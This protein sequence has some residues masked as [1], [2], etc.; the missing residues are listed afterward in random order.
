MN[1]LAQDMLARELRVAVLAVEGDLS[2]TLRAVRAYRGEGLE[3]DLEAFAHAEVGEHDP[4]QTRLETVMTA[5]P[6][7]VSRIF[8]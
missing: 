8:A 6:F 1:Q 3:E 2:E 5:D 7:G 4:I